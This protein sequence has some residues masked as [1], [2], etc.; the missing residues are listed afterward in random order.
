[1]DETFHV[2]DGRPHQSRKLFEGTEFGLWKESRNQDGEQTS[3]ITGS[4]YPR[5][6]TKGRRTE[7]EIRIPM[8]K[9]G[10]P[11]FKVCRLCR[12]DVQRRRALICRFPR[13][14]VGPGLCLSS[15]SLER[16]TQLRL[17]CIIWIIAPQR[18]FQAVDWLPWGSMQSFRLD[19]MCYS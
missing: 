10:F 9:K 13:S 6:R 3:C 16:V 5:P 7:R 18:P 12:E 11:L 2:R 17:H 14:H 1:M 4:F 8:L 15:V 19:C